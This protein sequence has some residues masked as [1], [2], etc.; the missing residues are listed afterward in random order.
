MLGMRR[1]YASPLRE[2]QAQATRV[3]I[4]EAAAR[5][6]ARGVV[7][8][9]I[10]AVARE[11]G[12]SVATVYRHFQTKSH[13]MDGLSSHLGDL[14][15]V[16]PNHMALQSLDQLEAK[17]L[18]ALRRRAQL[19]PALRQAIAH[20]EMNRMRTESRD[21]RLATTQKA[22]APHV[23]HLSPRDR[24]RAAEMIVLLMSSATSAA[25]EMLIGT[26][27]EHAA[28]TLSWAVRRIVAEDGSRASR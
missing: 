13:L 5:V 28:A 26:S 17:W 19:D 7:E 16:G 3:R 18:D 1:A 4:V 22:V 8:L 21:P 15:G 25:W 24:R 23:G 27:P 10:P 14:Q 12:V 20:P 2:A 9:S 11:A 6:L